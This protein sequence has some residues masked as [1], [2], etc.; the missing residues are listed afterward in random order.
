[1]HHKCIDTSVLYLTESSRKLSLKNL[2]F[3]YLNLTIQKV[4][5]FLLKDTHDSNED[6]KI[7]LSLAKLRIE[8]LDNF[9]SACFTQ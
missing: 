7:A 3:K 8:I 5:R 9:S 6:S 2:A 4:N 1:M